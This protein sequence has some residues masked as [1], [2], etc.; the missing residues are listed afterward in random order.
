MLSHMPMLTNF[1]KFVLM[2]IVFYLKLILK[3][4]IYFC[5]SLKVYGVKNTSRG[6]FCCVNLR[7]YVRV[8]GQTYVLYVYFIKY[9]IKKLIITF[10]LY[11]LLGTKLKHCKNNL[12]F[13]VFIFLLL[14]HIK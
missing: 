2:V 5:I 6:K 8:K 12:N 1:Y 7:Q 3:R 13:K 14:I 9:L 10:I 11:H 4:I